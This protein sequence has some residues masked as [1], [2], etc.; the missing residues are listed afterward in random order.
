MTNFA[1]SDL[2]FI[3]HEKPWRYEEDGLTV[4]RGSAWSGPGC[5]LGCGVLLYTDENGK[6]VKCEGDPEN[7]FNQGRLC[8]RCQNIQ[9]V[10]YHEDRLKYPMI[11]DPKDRGKNVW[12]RVSW[13]EALDL[14]AEKFNDIKAKHGAESVIFAQ[15]TGRDIGAAI[16]RL[17]WSFGSPNYTC[18]LSGLACFLPRIAGMALTMGTFMVVDSSVEWVDRYDDPRYEVPEVLVVWGN[19]PMIA[20]NEGFYGHWVVDMMKRGTKIIDVD[21]KVTW[22]SNKS[23]L[24]LPIR[25]GTDAAL[26]LGIINVICRED[27]Y[28]HDFV[29][30]WCYGFDELAERAAQFPVERV[31]EITWIPEQKIVDAARMIANAKSASLQWGL[32]VDM[33]KESL[34]ASQAMASIFMIT[35]NIDIPGGLVPTVSIL[36]YAAGWGS[37]LMSEEQKAKRIGLSEYPILGAGFQMAQA[38]RLIEA[39]ETGE[40]YEIHASWLQQTNI[41]SCI[42]ADPKRTQRLFEKLDFNV[43][44]DL[45][46]TPTIMALADVVL[47]ASTFAE[48]DSIRLG[49][50][51]QRA[52]V[53]C[54]A[55]EPV[56]ECKSDMEI[57]LLLGKRLAPEAW[58]WEN[59]T[60]V[61]DEL[62]KP[63][64]F[65]FNE[66]KEVAPV[67]LPFEYRRH[68]KGLLRPDGQPGFPTP[69][70]RLELWST[71]YE[72][73]GYDPLPYFEEPSPGPGSTPEL[74]EDYPLV[75]TTGARVWNSFHSEH[76]MIK[77]NRSY[78]PDPFIEVHPETCE[79][80]G[81]DEG[82]WV[83][84]ENHHGRAKRRVRKTPVLGPRIVA[85]DHGWWL[86]E[87][88]PEELFGLNDVAINNLIPWGEYGKTGFGA[89][90]KTNI[91]KIYK[92]A[93]GE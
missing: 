80:Y 16:T 91:C 25:P 41:L 38:D 67:F 21:P 44:V 5:H 46:M 2:T 77:R 72:S 57:N 8:M 92:V 53:I 1:K 17:S 33:T 52:E 76:R 55:V 19:Y 43:C 36:S 73:M 15:G 62:L 60:E 13:D 35:G 40:P 34:P 71:I 84:V 48:H 14:V 79:K 93:E 32:A 85:C 82:D 68:E 49:D 90:Y 69:T 51:I 45:F 27:L 37:E 61:L 26:A 9:E 3:D 20:N 87:E 81:V 24:H 59:V 31:S 18:I 6:L 4:T 78:T 65:T 50:G 29:D 66:L 64:G 42:A 7:P 23:A 28:D 22:L 10:I 86:P 58:P 56:G 47:P 63:T 89:N 30:K 12:K 39:M 75:L 70:G 74:M 11:R 54:Q 83:W 88:D